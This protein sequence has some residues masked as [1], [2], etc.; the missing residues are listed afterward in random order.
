MRIATNSI[1]IAILMSYLSL[2]QE[3]AEPAR[4]RSSSGGNAR[5]EPASQPLPTKPGKML[6]FEVLIADL[7]EPIDAPTA[8]N[9]LDLEKA[10]KLNSTSRMQLTSLE[11]EPAVVQFGQLTQR[12]T[13]Y[14]S[15]GLPAFGRGGPPG[16][17]VAAPA[18]QVTPIYN[19]TN[20]GTVV[21]IT[22]RIHDDGSI[23]AQLY[24]ERSGL[25]GGLQPP[26][27][28]NVATIPQSIDRMLSES[29]LHLKPG[30]P[31]ILG[32]RKSGAGK[33]TNKTW[34]V[35]TAHEGTR[36]PRPAP[37]SK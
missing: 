26:A 1:V 17:G 28:P 33:D 3:P 25:A 29:T 23:V 34:I 31:Q 27:D 30:E 35:I 11:N 18:P 10:G 37:A 12:V 14:S 6:T 36:P 5:R 19:N 4:A 24:V 13:G 7:A 16:G 32:G 9:V 8:V 22:A 2:G 20:V 21:Q 15:R